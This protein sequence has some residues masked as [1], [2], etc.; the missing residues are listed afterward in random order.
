MSK[1]GYL[2]SFEIR[3]YKGADGKFELYE[4]END[5]YNYEKGIHSTIIF[6]WD[7]AK[8]VL[9]ISER[10]GSFPSMLSER[11]FNIV[12][13]TPGKGIGMDA[14]KNFDKVINYKGKKVVVNL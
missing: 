3:I 4:D 6:T 12:I 14:V 1:Y 11:K 8:K 9:I 5:N 10:K 13:V 7:N 2:R